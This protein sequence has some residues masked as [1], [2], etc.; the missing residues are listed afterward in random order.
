MR[1]ERRNGME[2]DSPT[3][4]KFETLNVAGGDGKSIPE[5]SGPKSFVKVCFLK[6]FISGFLKRRFQFPIITGLWLLLNEMILTN[7]SQWN[8]LL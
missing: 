3:S 5:P 4:S 8:D 6:H 1:E 2:K 7:A